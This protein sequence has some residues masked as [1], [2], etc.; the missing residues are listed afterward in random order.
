M[1]II[2]TQLSENYKTPIVVF[3]NEY[4]KENFVKKGKMKIWILQHNLMDAESSWKFQDW[5]KFE[6]SDYF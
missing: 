4:K 2:D 3:K 6:V 5:Y 1:W